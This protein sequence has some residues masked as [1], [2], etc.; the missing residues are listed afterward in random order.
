MFNTIEPRRRLVN[1]QL[2]GTPTDANDIL[3]LKNTLAALNAIP[4]GT[5]G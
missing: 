4:A 3:V 1:A 5:G 2:A